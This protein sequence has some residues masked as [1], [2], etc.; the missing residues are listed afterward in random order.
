M[1]YFAHKEY[2]FKTFD[3]R[4]IQSGIRTPVQGSI[5][6]NEFMFSVTDPN[7][8]AQLNAYAGAYVELHY[9]EYLHTLPRRG[10]SQ[11]VE[12]SVVSVQKATLSQP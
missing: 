5:Q 10:I 7:V 9:K 3:G 4:L 2:L 6:S 1:N 12:D 11:F 8:A